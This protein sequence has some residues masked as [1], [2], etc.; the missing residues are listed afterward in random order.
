M[1]RRTT[2]GWGLVA[3]L[4]TKNS[5]GQPQLK[6]VVALLATAPK[7]LKYITAKYWVKNGK[8]TI[9]EDYLDVLMT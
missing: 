7:T 4:A 9:V 5:G 3:L 1:L 6:Q 8:T 2:S